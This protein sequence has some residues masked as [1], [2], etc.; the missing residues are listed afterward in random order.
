MLVDELLYGR[1]KDVIHKIGYR[2][3][4]PVSVVKFRLCPLLL[5]T[6]Y[7]VGSI[8]L[9]TLVVWGSRIA[10]KCFSLVSTRNRT[11][12]SGTDFQYANRYTTDLYV[13]LHTSHVTGLIREGRSD[14]PCASP[15]HIDIGL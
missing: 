11:W 8:Y 3:Y 9:K 14:Y 15:L 10:E 7:S 5:Q 4:I 12:I 2:D 1:L 13:H 6:G